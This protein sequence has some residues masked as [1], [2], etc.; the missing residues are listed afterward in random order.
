M[1]IRATTERVAVI[2]MDCCFPGAETGPESFWSLLADAGIAIEDTPSSR[3]DV[4]QHF[5]PD[6]DAPGKSYSRRGGFISSPFRF[7]RPFFRISEF[8]A[9]QM[10][11]QQRVMLELTWRALEHAAI[12]PSSLV[13]T[14]VGL[15]YAL[16][17]V[18]YARRTVQ[19]GE[20]LRINSYAKMG[21]N[22]AIGVGRVAHLLGFQGPAIAVDTTCSSSL[23]TVHLAAQALLSGD[24]DLA[25]AGGVNLILGPEETIGFASLRAMSM[26]DTCRPFDEAA[27]GYMRGE[28][29]GAVVLKRLSDAL[30]DGNRIDAVIAGSAVNNDGPSNGLTAPNGMA[31]LKLIRKALARAELRPEAIDFV[32]AHGTGT[33]LGDP[34]ELNALHA[35]YCDGIARSRPL[36]LGA[37]KANIGHLESAAGIAGFI[38]T[39]MSLKARAVAR[40]PRF[41][42]PTS[43]FRWDKSALRVPV[44]NEVL[45]PGAAA[46]RGAVSS[47]GLSGTN[48]HIIVESAPALAAPAA[49]TPVFRVYPMS[50]RSDDSL[51]EIVRRHAKAIVSAKGSLR[52]ACYTVATREH[53]REFRLAAVGSTTQE[54]SEALTCAA[55]GQ[56]SWGVVSGAPDG[57]RGTGF[58]FPG[59]GAWKAGMGKSLFESNP[60]FRAKVQEV[61]AIV[62]PVLGRPLEDVLFSGAV[63]PT[64]HREAQIAHFTL[65]WALHGTFTALG[66]VPVAVLGHSL[67]EHVAACVAGVFTLPDAVDL[68]LARGTAYDEAARLAPGGM[69][70]VECGPAMLPELLGD[71][72]DRVHLAVHNSPTQCVI[73]GL[74]RDLVLA[75][76]SLQA[77]GL[78]TKSL[79]VYGVAGHS[80][81][82]GSVATAL[83]K[84]LQGLRLSSPRLPYYSS[85]FGREASDEVATPEYWVRVALDTVR[86][87]DA[88]TAASARCAT[89]FEVAGAPSLLKAIRATSHAA[90]QVVNLLSALGEGPD[91]SRTDENF[92]FARSLAGLYAAGCEIEWHRLFGSPRPNPLALPPYAFSGQDYELQPVYRAPGLAGDPHTSEPTSRSRLERT[93]S[94]DSPAWLSDHVLHGRV[95][96]P[97]AGYCVAAVRA[98]EGEGLGLP[99]QLHAISFEA[100]LWVDRPVVLAT[101]LTPKGAGHHEIAFSCASSGTDELVHCSIESAGG[102][103][104]MS[105]PLDGEPS[106][107]LDDVSL[108]SLQ[109]KW[110]AAGLQ[111]GGTFKRIRRALANK[112]CA[113]VIVEPV[114]RSADVEETT[115]DAVFQSAGVLASMVFQGA[116]MPLA[117]DALQ[118]VAPMTGSLRCVSRRRD[119]GETPHRFIADIDVYS[120]RQRVAVVRGLV[121]ADAGAD[122]STRSREL[123]RLP[124]WVPLEPLEPTAKRFAH[125]RWLVRAMGERGELDGRWIDASAAGQARPADA[126]VLRLD[127]A[128]AWT[129]PVRSPADEEADLCWALIALCRELADSKT[130]PEHVFVVTRGVSGATAG[131]A[132]L[133]G[134]SVPG[135]LRSLRLE[136]PAIQWNWIDVEA[137]CEQA[138]VAAMLPASARHME[139]AWRSDGT[140]LRRELRTP[141]QP[142]DTWR[143]AADAWHIVTGAFGALGRE[144]V[145]SL[146]GRGARH[147][148]LLARSRPDDLADWLDDTSGDAELVAFDVD[149]ADGVAVQRTL[150]RLLESRRPAG[151]VH[152]AGVIRDASIF[153][154]QRGDVEECFAGKARGAWNLHLATRALPLD[155][156]VLFSSVA[157]SLG[158][159]GQCH[160]AAANAF[161]DQVAVHRQRL[162]LPCVSIAWGLWGEAGAGTSETLRTKAALAG[163]GTLSTDFAISALGAAAAGTTTGYIVAAT[164]E[165]PPSGAAM[166]MPQHT[167]LDAGV[168]SAAK[169]AAAVREERLIDLVTEASGLVRGKLDADTPLTALGFDS[170]A[171]VSLRTRLKRELQ[172]EIP[173]SVFM[174]GVSLRQLIDALSTATAVGSRGSEVAPSGPVVETFL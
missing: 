18:D 113:E 88:V 152:C 111:F 172:L 81:L 126:V 62:G 164:T 23:V 33:P 19:S 124:M 103:P 29:A 140:A 35:A 85:V 84:R 144:V 64:G 57:E 117:I 147:I 80:P 76:T 108:D 120:G 143:P 58:V 130:P 122:S 96:F 42:K 47:F 8:E 79:E 13:E 99:V 77:A 123:I 135:L 20:I 150:D 129:P 133:Y 14:E 45:S 162:G 121:F 105:A 101:A 131:H 39:V 46:V 40:H 36:W 3:F 44:V 94:A 60:F 173:V 137:C 21:A 115:L 92:A 156:F 41:D 106:S 89:L 51:R 98:L 146:V 67:G 68:V 17:D 16:G 141:P 25:L 27:D 110:L 24:C 72:F 2:G 49:M 66:A 139:T 148:A 125:V 50:A 56:F 82:V 70:A 170:L 138:A 118:I 165:R 31:Q 55:S 59:Q 78:Q 142:H 74:E 63:G 28:G 1:S 107:V 169:P 53:H 93:L 37:A 163:H 9:L 5:D 7:D 109:A 6:P 154:T 71:L 61:S 100:P 12:R 145:K 30:R 22:R 158:N 136:L 87:H 90:G 97:G 161:I 48:A 11:P 73:S 132:N 149:V 171:L 159:A 102:C 119:S 116:P 38:K 95:L 69:L 15:Y 157:A 174:R 65:L 26:T 160:Y 43:R 4:N 128:N 112:R 153:A 32:E 86:F 127:D 155:Y 91:M 104:G 52:D 114:A 34:I 167:G 10:D 83:R 168:T 54:L 166:P 75:S 134:S 151:V